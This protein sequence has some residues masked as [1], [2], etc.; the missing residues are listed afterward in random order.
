MATT[1]IT[2]SASGQNL[3]LPS[4]N[5]IVR[6]TT[7]HGR[8]QGVTGSDNYNLNF[9]V[10]E[11]IKMPVAA[12]MTSGPNV[13]NPVDLGKCIDCGNNQLEYWANT[14][15]VSPTVGDTYAINVTYS[16]GTSETL[17]GSVSAV[18]NAFASNL[19]PYTGS[20]ISVTPTFTWTYPSNASSYLYEFWISDNNGNNLWQ[21][22]GNNS[23][24]NGFSNSVSSI[25]WGTDPTGNT[26]NTPSVTTLTL[27]TSYMWNIQTMDNN[28]NDA[29]ESVSYVP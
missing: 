14:S 3:T 2:G 7:S 8:Q 1:S 18:L 21:I 10:R 4:G 22:P 6:V 16:D 13:I 26:G 29:V 9:D 19:A 25:V 27:G 15:T 24:S 23:N 11:G 28:G 17:N 5:A 12:Q 20:S